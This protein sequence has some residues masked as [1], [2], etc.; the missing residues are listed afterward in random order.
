MQTALHIAALVAELKRELVGGTVVS[1]EFYKKE[2]A[3]YFKIKT[4]EKPWPI[5]GLDGSELLDVVQCG[6]D[7]MFKIVLSKKEE[8]QSALFEAIGPNG[9]I[10]L[11]DK[12]DNLLATLRNKKFNKG[13]PYTAPGPPADRMNPLEIDAQS[14]GDGIAASEMS[15]VTFVEKRIAGFSRT[16]AREA[17]MR[18]GV[19]S[20]GGHDLSRDQSAAVARAIKDMA[21]RFINSESGYLYSIRGTVEVYPFKLTVADSQPEK[22]KT[23]SLAVQCMTGRRQAIVEEVDEQKTIMSLLGRAAK[24]LERRLKNLEGDIS[25]AADFELYRKLGE[26]LQINHSLMKKGMSSITV[27]DAYADPGAEIEISL[28]PARSPSENIDNYFKRYRKGREGLE[29]L[30]RRQ[31]I[32]RRELEQLQTMTH[33]FDTGF[34]ASL[35]RY[36]AEIAALRPRTARKGETQIRLPYRE[37]SLSTG[38]TIFVGR[39]GADNDRT[40]FEFAKPFELWFHTQQCPGSHVVM[41]YPNK[42]FQPSKAEIEETAAA[43]AYHSKARKDSLVPVIYTHRR[44]V[45]KPRKAKPGLVMVEREKSVM[46]APQKP[47]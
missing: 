45:R 25:R 31:E 16:M 23:L 9:N 29:L 3:A 14:F 15:P 8:T 4:R 44:Y 39:E 32:S 2:R 40:T 18:S 38:L 7:R 20:S 17:I 1:T 35:E 5:F 24:K 12:K 37:H 6:I 27:A 26:L 47:D 43:A 22:L 21:E 28:D 42:S 11:L 33:D 41:K 10:W 30:Q 36:R 34:E 13:E 19:D 46:V